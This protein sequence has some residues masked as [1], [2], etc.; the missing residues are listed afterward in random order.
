M[1]D[2][3]TFR[4]F[5]ALR[6]ASIDLERLTVLVG[7][8][9]SGKTSVLEGLWYLSELA[10]KSPKEVFSGEDKF[11]QL[12]TRETRTYFHL[13]CDGTH[14][15]RLEVRTK[16]D[17]K[18]IDWSTFDVDSDVE[19]IRRGA[20]AGR[21]ILLQMVTEHLAAPS[22]SEERLPCLKSN[23]EG[24]ASVLAYLATNEPERHRELLEA[25]RSI[26]PAVDKIRFPRT[27]VVRTERHT[28]TVDGRTYDRLEER[29]YWGNSIEFD[30]QAAPGIAGSMA[31]EGTL[32]VLGILASMIAPPRPHLVLLDDFDRALHPRAQGQMVERLRELL[33]AYPDLQ[34][35]ATSHSP[36][37]LDHLEPEEVRITTLKGNGSVAIGRL[38]DHP[39]FEKWKEEMSPGE[40]WS[41]VGE[42][43]VAEATAGEQQD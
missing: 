26:V 4:N 3:V 33:A 8:N 22:Y 35:V 6:H 16:R 23:G 19:V 28:I 41:V 38:I 13:R 25:V 30:M 12:W 24:L 20:V 7:P 2:R 15:S 11:R 40:F 1:I 9:A 37:L 5:K 42:Q 43:W 21:A 34:I 29:Q 18:D 17:W 39:Q 32:L 31:S 27:P 36:Y 10:E 14:G